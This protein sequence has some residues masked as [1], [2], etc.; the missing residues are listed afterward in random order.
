MKQDIHQ[1]YNKTSK[2]DEDNK[3]DTVFFYQRFIGRL[4]VCSSFQFGP[5]FTFY[6]YNLFYMKIVHT[7]YVLVAEINTL[8]ISRGGCTHFKTANMS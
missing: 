8:N 5:S 2:F 7:I 1:N 6:M 4:V 3:M